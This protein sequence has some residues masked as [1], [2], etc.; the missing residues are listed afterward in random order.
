VPLI[1]AAA[2]SVSF[3]FRTFT[4]GKALG[5]DLVLAS[6]ALLLALATMR[7]CFFTGKKTAGRVNPCEVSQFSLS[8]F[9]GSPFWGLQQIATV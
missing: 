6:M 8:Q 5:T 7:L 4:A 9:G 1:V 2:I 3:F